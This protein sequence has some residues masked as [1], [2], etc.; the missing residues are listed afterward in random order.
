M[1]LNP[2]ENRK[3]KKVVKY[4]AVYKLYVYL[5]KI[6]TMRTF[7]FNDWLYDNMTRAELIAV[8]DNKD[9]H[10]QYHVDKCKLKLEDKYGITRD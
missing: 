2:Q 9:K 6:I 4:F 5:Y 7:K 10:L 8:I 3:Q 1:G